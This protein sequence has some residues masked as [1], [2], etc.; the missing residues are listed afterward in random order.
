M[1]RGTSGD[2]NRFF[3]LWWDRVYHED[4]VLA[5]LYASLIYFYVYIGF[6]CKDGCT[7]VFLLPMKLTYPFKKRYTVH[8][9]W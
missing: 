5:G 1:D 3:R 7:F 9:G 6:F 2:D 8:C 4:E